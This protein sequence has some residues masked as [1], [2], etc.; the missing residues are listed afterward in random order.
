MKFTVSSVVS[1]LLAAVQV[2]S[3]TPLQADASCGKTCTE[4]SDCTGTCNYCSKPAED[5][6]QCRDFDTMKIDSFE[7][8]DWKR[9]EDGGD[10]DSMKID[11]F[12][13]GDW[14]RDY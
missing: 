8:P 2:V 14:K 4:A 6:W 5:R 10:P 13:K 12:E 11:G 1:V 7:K 3:A 9:D